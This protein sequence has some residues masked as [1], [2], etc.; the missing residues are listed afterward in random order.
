MNNKLLLNSSWQRIV[1]ELSEEDVK[2]VD[3]TLSDNS[4]LHNILCTSNSVLHTCNI[5]LHN[6]DI[7]TIELHNPDRK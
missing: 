4:M 2:T 6:A 3:V 1:S 5:Q 7:Q